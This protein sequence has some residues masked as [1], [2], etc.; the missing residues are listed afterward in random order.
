MQV[1]FDTDV[2]ADIFT[3]NDRCLFSFA[4]YDV[5]VLR[6]FT[7]CLTA[8]SV[9]DLASLIAGSKR[10]DER[11]RLLKNVFSLF[12]I[13]DVAKSDCAEACSGSI[14]DYG[15]ALL[16][17]IAKRTGTGIVISHSPLRAAGPSVSVM[18][19]KTFTEAYK[20][21][22]IAYAQVNLKEVT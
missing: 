6:G 7:P 1:L 13:L 9:I 20:P 16:A 19:P 8:S 5:C 12:E 3:K 22:D 4:A 21:N 2:V 17:A 15:E 18:D 10:G 11:S 14:E